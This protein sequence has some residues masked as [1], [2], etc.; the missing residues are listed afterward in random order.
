MYSVKQQPGILP[1]RVRTILFALFWIVLLGVPSGLVIYGGFFQPTPPVEP[2]I[3][4]LDTVAG[5]DV[6]VEWPADGIAAIG[7]DG[8]GVLATSESA[9]EPVPIASISKLFLALAIME[10]R[11]FALGED[12]ERI[13]MS[14]ADE[15]LYNSYVSR[16]GS[17]YPV[18]AGQQFTQYQAMQA[19]LIPSANNIA[20]TLATWAFGSMQGYLEYANSMV[21]GMGLD[22]TTLADASG[23][24]PES[25]STPAELVLTGQA[26]LDNEVIAD[27]VARQQA[28]IYPGVETVFSTNQL[29][30]DPGVIGIKTG[31]TDEAGA[32]LLFGARHALTETSEATIVGVVMGQSERTVLY[33]EARLLLQSA[34]QGFGFVEVLEEGAVVGAYQAPWMD[35]PVPIVSSGG[36]VVP[37]WTGA[38][39]TPTAESESLEPGNIP[40]EQIGTAR[41]QHGAE[42]TVVP[43]VTQGAVPEPSF[44][45][46]VKNVFSY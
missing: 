43:L 37:A 17:A 20:D 22:Q 45:W 27:I 36:A 31:T 35:E 6:S 29:L 38:D 5:Q 34:Y 16:G 9:N 21:A 15:D 26:A 7:A 25:V 46:K 3:Y 11:P 2:N 32:N 10:A 23:F 13:T 8:Y 19:L 42:T 24:S 39:I 30:S 12:G 18:N 33:E 44:W 40:G 4:T 14:Q 28:Q 1:E 41:I